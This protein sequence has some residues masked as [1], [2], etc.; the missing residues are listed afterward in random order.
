MWDMSVHIIKIVF[1]GGLLL[2]FVSEAP[3]DPESPM[4]LWPTNQI[5]RT[6]ASSGA[7]PR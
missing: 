4:S 6:D 3:A 7:D 5:R 2:F 1:A